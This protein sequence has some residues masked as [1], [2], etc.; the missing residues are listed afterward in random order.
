[1]ST[2]SAQA[3]SELERKIKELTELDRVITNG[4]NWISDLEVKVAYIGPVSE[5]VA[6][7]Q[8]FKANVAQQREVLKPLVEEKSE[9]IVPEIVA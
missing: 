8:G 5:F 6:F 9:A 2:Q 4:I 3:A 1:M 7:L